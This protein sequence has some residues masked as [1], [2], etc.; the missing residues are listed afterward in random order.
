MKNLTREKTFEQIH[1][2]NKWG[3]K[4]SVSGS[5]S[6]KK[7]TKEVLN[8]INQVLEDY[9]IH[10]IL[11]IP[12][13]DFNWIGDSNVTEIEY[14]GADIVPEIIKS[15]NDKF[16]EVAKLTFIHSDVVTSK[17]PKVDLVFTRDCLVHLS[18]VEVH[19]ALGNIAKS[20]STYLLTTSFTKKIR[21]S[22][23]ATHA[24]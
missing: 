11:D 7:T 22:C 14:V 17:L 23:R 8:I 13:G 21:K 18:N 15:N 10:S 3:S 2:L 4:E 6:E 20:N 16:S 12:C 5:G 1:S 19:L 9:N 24:K